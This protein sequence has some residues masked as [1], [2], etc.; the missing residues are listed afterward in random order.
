MNIFFLSLFCILFLPVSPSKE[1]GVRVSDQLNTLRSLLET[2]LTEQDEINHRSF[3]SSPGTFAKEFLHSYKYKNHSNDLISDLDD[4]EHEQ[5]QLNT[6][7]YQSDALSYSST[8]SI[9]RNES[10]L[11]DQLGHH[12]NLRSTYTPNHETRK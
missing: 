3:K 11:T 7:K 2:R 8:P 1:Y 9:N 10:T 5:T 12:S 6:A 4:E